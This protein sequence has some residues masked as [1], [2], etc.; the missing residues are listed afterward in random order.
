MMTK[1]LLRITIV[2]SVL[3]L[4]IAAC[5][6]AATETAPAATAVPPSASETSPPAEP[7]ATDVPSEATEL[8]APPTAE[9]TAVPTEAPPA[10]EPEQPAD[11]GE[12]TAVA[13]EDI[14]FS[15]PSFLAGSVAT[16]TVPA[17]NEPN[18]PYWA[19][20]PETFRFS[21]ENYLL[22][23]T[24]HQ[25]RIEVYPADEFASLNSSAKEEIDALRTLLADKP[26]DIPAGGGAKLPFLPQFNAAQVIRV[27]VEYLPFQNGEGVRYLTH[28]AQAVSPITNNT[29]FYTYQ[30]LTNDGAYYISA[31]FPV[32]TDSLPDET[33]FNS[34][35][36][37][38]FADNFDNY[39]QDLTAMLNSLSDSGFEPS[40]EALDQAVQSIS[41]D[42]A[43]A[44]RRTD[45]A[46]NVLL[47]LTYPV[48]NGQVVIGEMLEVRGYAAPG[49]SP[50]EVALVA[51]ENTLASTTTSVDDATGDWAATLTV[52]PNVIGRA[53]VTATTSS[54]RDTSSVQIVEIRPEPPQP[55][56]TTIRLQRPFLGET[57]V[58]GYPVYFEGEVTNPINNSVTIGVLIDDCT[59]FGARQSFE[60]PGGTWNGNVILPREIAGE[61]ACAF[62]FTGTYGEGDWRE[63]QTPLPILAPDD[64]QANRISLEQFN[65]EFT[66]GQSARIAGMAVD[67]PEVRVLVRS[68][69][70]DS[71]LVEGTAPVEQYGFWEMQL[72]IPADAPD[73]VR[74][75][76]ML[77]EEGVDPP[78]M[79]QTGASV[80]R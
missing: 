70:D 5:G 6:G 27:Q 75:D 1:Q 37:Q 46:G 12:T 39:L 53:R 58:A 28:Y 34:E 66:A 21:F 23:D 4:A 50:V 57:A 9:P 25:P 40:L 73:F 79:L 35:E 14:S 78:I 74:L 24:F 77:V 76:V 43:A 8:P 22:A 26:Q 42:R 41:V 30:G 20:L 48:E 18:Q 62:A 32:R 7:D 52:P 11:T 3:V 49:A 63:M 55:T 67:A 38:T 68:G 17:S 45:D 2:L 19:N 69:A 59:R 44:Q 80:N 72:P 64:P 10:D 31:I 29:L 16:E 33:N 47:T 61:E 71:V 54:E 51:G 36:Y 60:V 65:L 13:Y 15:Y 56:E